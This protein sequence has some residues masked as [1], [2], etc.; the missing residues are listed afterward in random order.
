MTL[1]V[2]GAKQA[3]EKSIAGTVRNP[4]TPLFL[5]GAGFQGKLE[6]TRISRTARTQFGGDGEPTVVR[7]DVLR[8][9]YYDVSWRCLEERERVAKKGEPLGNERVSRQYVDGA[10]IDDHLTQTVY[11]ESGTAVERTL[12]YCQNARG[13]VVALTDEG[14]ETV[15]RLVYSPYGEA[16][17]IGENG[18]LREFGDAELAAYAFQGRR[19]DAETGLMEFRA[20]LRNISSRGQLLDAC[21]I[22]ASDFL[23]RV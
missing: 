13:D 2:N 1:L 9:Y 10:G 3:E 12:Y 14:G 20:L 15:L 19:I 8:T 22:K 17:E 23:P 11:D 5:G 18:E 7:E 21:K 6:E 16:R 4:R